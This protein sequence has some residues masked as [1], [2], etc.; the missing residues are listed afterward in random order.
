MLKTY[1]GFFCILK[2]SEVKHF[3]KRERNLL[4]HWRWG[5]GHLHKIQVSCLTSAKTDLKPGFPGETQ[6]LFLQ[7]CWLLCVDKGVF[8]S[9]LPFK[10]CESVLNQEV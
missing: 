3:Q 7:V 8:S 5:F 4:I 1:L 9:E 2:L 10:S 6:E